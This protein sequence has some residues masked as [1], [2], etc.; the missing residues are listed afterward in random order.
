MTFTFHVDPKEVIAIARVLNADDVGESVASADVKIQKDV[1]T[2]LV[3][4]ASMENLMATPAVGEVMRRD[5]DRFQH[6]LRSHRI[7]KSRRAGR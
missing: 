3:M 7:P 1:C 6:A 2:R 5:Y 4:R